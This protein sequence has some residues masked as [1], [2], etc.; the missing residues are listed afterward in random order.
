[1]EP[2]RGLLCLSHSGDLISHC[3]FSFICHFSLSLLIPLT[4][5]L[6]HPLILV[7]ASSPWFHLFCSFYLTFLFVLQMQPFWFSKQGMTKVNCIEQIVQFMMLFLKTLWIQM[8]DERSKLITLW[9]W[10][11]KISCY[12]HEVHLIKSEQ[13][14][15]GRNAYSLNPLGC[16]CPK[17]WLQVK[18]N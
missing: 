5:F 4:P 2:Q 8:Y 3:F 13:E 17:Y 14:K 11:K 9:F 16:L 6:L 15:R 1:M 10:R 12:N 7:N 18:G